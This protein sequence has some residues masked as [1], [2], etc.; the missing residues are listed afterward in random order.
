M[1]IHNHSWFLVDPSSF[2]TFQSGVSLLIL[3]ASK[4]FLVC[5]HKER[6]GMKEEIVIGARRKIC[7]HVAGDT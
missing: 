3:E 5:L 2:K 7:I 1:A 4:F 6:S